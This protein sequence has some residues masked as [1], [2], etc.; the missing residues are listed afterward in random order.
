M[1]VPKIVYFL[2]YAY[3]FIL[4]G[5]IITSL[6]PIIPYFSQVTNEPEASYSYIFFVRAGGY[7]AGGSLIKILTKMYST[8]NI[9]IGV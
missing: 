5:S 2:A 8:H 6:G 9:L 7:L 1:S 4:Y 3:A